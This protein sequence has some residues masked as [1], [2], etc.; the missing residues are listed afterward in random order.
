[1]ALSWLAAGLI[2]PPLAALITVGSS[3]TI[4]TST[5]LFLVVPAAAL[6]LMRPNAGWSA[7]LFA[8]VVAMPAIIWIDA[9]AHASGQW[10]VPTS[11]ME[12]RPWHLVSHETLFWAVAQFYHAAMLWEFG[13]ERRPRK[14]L[15]WRRVGIAGTLS[16]SML[17]VFLVLRERG[18]DGSQVRYFYSW[19][20][21]CLILSPIIGAAVLRPELKRRLLAVGLYA[22]YNKLI[23]ELTALSLGFWQFPGEFLALIRVGPFQIPIE[24]LVFWIGLMTPATAIYYEYW[25]GGANATSNDAL[26][27][28]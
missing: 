3:G 18:L 26:K 19:F 11:P 16:W 22:A 12:G 5:F 21:F 17:A 28:A 6:T 24:E 7:A 13:N 9:L 1:M 2:W 8:G 20:G 23:F 27:T 25:C 10:V 14:N 15:S 4:D